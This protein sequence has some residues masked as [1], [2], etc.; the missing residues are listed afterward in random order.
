V[1]AVVHGVDPIVRTDGDAVCARR[2]DPLAPG[3]EKI[4]P[5][6]IDHHP[7]VLPGHQIDIILGVDR[8]P[9]HVLVNVPG[10]QLLPSFNDLECWNHF[11]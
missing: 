2:E 4:A 7:G 10:R 1:V 3:A 11:H 8:Y 5:P 9:V 6:V